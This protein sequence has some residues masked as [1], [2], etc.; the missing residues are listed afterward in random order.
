MDKNLSN[1][2]MESRQKE[3]RERTDIEK[4]KEQDKER[5]CIKLQ[6]AFKPDNKLFYLQWHVHHTQPSL[7]TPPQKSE[8]P[9]NIS[10][11]LI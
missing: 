6:T 9:C 2:N 8:H 7:P 3:E 10:N 5:K 11:G 4:A 1:I